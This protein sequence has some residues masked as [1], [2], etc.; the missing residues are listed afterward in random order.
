MALEIERKYLVKDDSYKA[1]AEKKYRIRQGYLQRIP[2]RTVR[3]RTKDNRGFLTVKGKNEGIVREEFE[4]EIPYTDAVSMLALCEGTIIDK[5]RYIIAYN[6]L[7]WEVDEFHGSLSPLTV[8]EV[9]LPADDYVA[10]IPEF[11][12]QEVTGDPKYYNSM[13]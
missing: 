5:T 3:V 4:Y 6:G 9:E 13:M 11:I 2:E 8:A 10:E 7:T 12:G 1:L